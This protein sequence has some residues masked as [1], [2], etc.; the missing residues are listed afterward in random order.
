MQTFPSLLTT[1][2]ALALTLSIPLATAWTLKACGIVYYSTGTIACTTVSCPAGQY[3]DFDDGSTGRPI[4]LS[5]YGDA[6]CRNEITHFAR[7][8]TDYRLPRDLKSILVLT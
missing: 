2:T 3:I 4:E 5:L 7:N 1:F 8:E 6:G